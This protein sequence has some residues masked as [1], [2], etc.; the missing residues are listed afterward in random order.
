MNANTQF[1]AAADLK[2]ALVAQKD[3]LLAEIAKA[4]D[5]DEIAAARRLLGYFTATWTVVGYGYKAVECLH[6]L[7]ARLEHHNKNY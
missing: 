6:R 7:K 5:A 4:N 2:N 1:D 3:A